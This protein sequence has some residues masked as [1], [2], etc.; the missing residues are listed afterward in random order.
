MIMTEAP[1]KGG[2][3]NSNNGDDFFISRLILTI[4]PETSV[5]DYKIYVLEKSYKTMKERMFIGSSC[6]NQNVKIAVTQILK[7]SFI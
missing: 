4:Y 6:L 5:N 7:K 3:R 2:R 1:A